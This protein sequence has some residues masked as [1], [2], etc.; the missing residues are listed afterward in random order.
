MCHVRAPRQRHPQ[1][2]PP[3]RPVNKP[4]HHRPRSRSCTSIGH[5]TTSRQERD[6]PGQ[7]SAPRTVRHTFTRREIVRHACKLLPFWPIKGGGAAPSC[8]DTG[9]R[10]A[11]THTLFVFST[12]LALASINTSGTW[13]L[14]L[15]CRFAC[16]HP[17]T[18]TT[19]QV[20][21]CPEHALLDVRPRPEPG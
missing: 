16:S 5:T 13:R 3:R 9:R 6:S 10:T 2:G 17:S 7:P 1:T 21:Q 19:V 15:L 8:G 20:I 11:I 4:L 18:S 12:I 14:R